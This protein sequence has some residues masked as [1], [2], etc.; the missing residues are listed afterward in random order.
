MTNRHPAFHH[1]ND[2]ETSRDGREDMN[3]I[4]SST[5]SHMTLTRMRL[6]PVAYHW[7]RKRITILW[8]ESLHSVSHN[9]SCAISAI[10]LSIDA[11]PGVFGFLV[12]P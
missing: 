4:T 5:W 3:S 12:K 10:A 9:F 7:N 6:P 2:R 11:R 8:S 1:A